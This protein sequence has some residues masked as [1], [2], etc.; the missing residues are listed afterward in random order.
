MNR[1]T[2]SLLLF[3]VF[4]VSAPLRAEP[5]TYTLD[6]EHVTVGF[7]VAHV[8]YAKVLGQF[9]KVRGSYRFDDATG[10]LGDVSIIVDT[11][12]VSTNHEERDEHLRSRDFLSSKS[13][14]EMTFTS[15]TARPIGEGTFEI[16]GQ[17][18]LRGETHPLKLTATVNK[19]AEYP[20]GGNAYVMGVSARGSLKRSDYGIVYGVENGW[21]GDEVEIIVEFEARRE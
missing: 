4:G 19:S 21:V 5:A 20:F 2:A 15:A 13:F 16:E 10:E 12:S 14:P 8:G 6:P 7:L 3:C 9:L 18:A 11:A 1:G 17:L